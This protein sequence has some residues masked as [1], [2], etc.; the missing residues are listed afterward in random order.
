M[1]RL[2]VLLFATVPIFSI[3]MFFWA[4]GAP[5]GH[6]L[7]ENITP[8]GKEIDHLF[9]VILGITGV[10]FVIVQVALLYFMWKYG[11][12]DDPGKGK[13][14]HG[15]HKLET[16]WTII[17]AAILAFI[18]FYQFGA[19][20][21]IKFLNKAPATTIHARVLGGQFEWRM[22]Y[23]HRDVVSDLSTS[24]EELWRG[25][26]LEMVNELHA[27]KNQPVLLRIQSR[28]V[29]HSFYIPATRI[30]QDLVPGMEKQVMWFTPTESGEYEIACAELCGWGHY[31]MKGKF[32]VHENEAE[33]NDWYARAMAA[34]NAD[35][36]DEEVAQR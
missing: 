8:A 12:K 19:W 18:A 17:P 31:K 16:V 1:K 10:T 21:D 2:W 24:N 3:G 14:T 25:G 27:W 34:Q 28:D 6:W 13:F 20:Q 29:L 9:W 35:Q 32:V 30:K 5:R 15:N 22:R 26:E 11:G 23:P 7:P 33:F 4:A 36:T